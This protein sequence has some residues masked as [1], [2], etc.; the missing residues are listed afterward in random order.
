MDKIKVPVLFPKQL[1]RLVLDL[2][3]NTMIRCFAPGPVAYAFI[4]FFPYTFDH[5]PYLPIAKVDNNRGL[6][7]GDL[8]VYCLMDDVKP[9]CFLPAHSDNVLFRHNA[10][11]VRQ[12][13]VPE[14]RTFLLWLNRTLSFWDYRTFSPRPPRSLQ[15]GQ[16]R[17]TSV[18]MSFCNNGV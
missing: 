6:C 12:S 3:G 1:E 5:P 10:L 15:R 16:I 2:L 9:F 18:S 8:L 4:A 17:T 7:L 14:N 13:I 11:P